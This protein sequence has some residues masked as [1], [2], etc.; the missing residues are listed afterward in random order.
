[1]SEIDKVLPTK[2]LGREHTVGRA[3]SSRAPLA[4][5]RM[6]GVEEKA[7]LWNLTGIGLDPEFS[8]KVVCPWANPLVSLNLSKNNSS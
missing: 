3:S 7:E 6:P 1:M 4:D 5:T 2:G 8:S